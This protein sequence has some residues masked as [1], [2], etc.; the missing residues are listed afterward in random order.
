MT[1]SWDQRVERI[2]RVLGVSGRRLVESSEGWVV[3]AGTDRRRRPLLKLAPDEVARSIAEQR[4]TPTKGG[5]FVIPATRDGIGDGSPGDQEEPAA[6]PW[7][8]ERL[9][10]PRPKGRGFA[11]LAQQAFRAEGPLT[12]RQASAGLQLIED[13]EQASR[14]PGLTMNWDAGPADKKRRGPGAPP[15]SRASVAATGRIRRVREALAS[16]ETDFPLLW[17]A[18]VQ[19]LSLQGLQRRFNFTRRALGPALEGALERLADAYVGS[20]AP[21]RQPSGSGRASN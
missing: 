11:A 7:V 8:Y 6:G 12:M 21:L 10:A 3:I 5:G 9:S 20:S 15:A 4:I 18:C 17:A 19:Q 16:R 1:A 14:D 2:T 13:A